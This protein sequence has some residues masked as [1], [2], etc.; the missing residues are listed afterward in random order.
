M[1]LEQVKRNVE[2][3]IKTICKEIKQNNGCGSE[4]IGRLSQLVNAYNRLIKENFAEYDP[5]LD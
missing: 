3:T 4:K 5:E 1:S 2:S